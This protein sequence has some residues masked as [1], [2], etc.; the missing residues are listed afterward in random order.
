MQRVFAAR[1]V[2]HRCRDWWHQAMCFGVRWRPVR[3]AATRS[4]TRAVLLVFLHL[5]QCWFVA[6]NSSDA[7]IARGRSVFRTD[8]M[9]LTRVR[10]ARY[11]DDYRS[12]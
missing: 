1:S 2:Y 9:F 7:S 8:V 10:S 4:P 5:D 12:W 3:P 6:V 11:F